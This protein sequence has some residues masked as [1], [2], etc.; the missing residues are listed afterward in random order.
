[1]RRGLFSCSLFAI[2]YSLFVFSGGKCVDPENYTIECRPNGVL[3][4]HVHSCDP[5]G[6]PLPDAV[7]TFRP[8]DPQYEIWLKRFGEQK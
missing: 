1:M 2:H 3:L 7:F 6:R 8:N 5:D 4:V